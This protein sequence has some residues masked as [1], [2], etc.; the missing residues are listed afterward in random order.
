MSLPRSIILILFLPVLFFGKVFFA[1]AF[2]VSPLGY[3]L[4][5]DPGKS[6]A[7]TISIVNNE[8]AKHSY[9]ISVQSLRISED[10]SRIYQKN[11]DPA[12]SWVVIKPATFNLA[13]GA[14]KTVSFTISVPRDQPP[15]SRSLVLMVASIP[16][17]GQTIGLTAKSA[18]PIFLIVS[19][20][21]N[22]NIIIDRWQALKGL[23]FDRRVPLAIEIYNRGTINTGVNGTITVFDWQGRKIYDENTRFGSSIFPDSARRLAPVITLPNR[24]WPGKYLVKL[25]LKYGVSKT[26]ISAE[27]EIWYL[28]APLIFII[29]ALVIAISIFLWRRKK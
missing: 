7:A 6:Q 22:E 29:F 18:I 21:V 16:P 13:P 28:P 4:T 24:T 15:G 26:A 12:E 14:Q 20:A 25:D 11:F 10:G 17:S 5:I 9:E 1:S 8:W 2:T 19:G 27:T 3:T 23:V